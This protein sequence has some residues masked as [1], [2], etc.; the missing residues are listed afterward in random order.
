MGDPARREVYGRR[1]FLFYK[2]AITA[3]DRTTYTPILLMDAKVVGW[4]RNY[5]NEAVG[6]RIQPEIE[7]DKSSAPESPTVQP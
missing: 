3:E 7:R 4:G 5:Y 1:E 6:S 2:T